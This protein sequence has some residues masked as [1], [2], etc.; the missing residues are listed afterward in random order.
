MLSRLTLVGLG[1]TGEA[2]LL[3]ALLE[4]LGLKICLNLPGKPSDFFSGFSFYGQPPD[5]VILSAHGDEEGIIFPQ[6]AEGVDTLTLPGDRITP[7]LIAER[8]ELPAVPIVSTA[9]SSGT[10]A[11][12]QAFFTA[13]ASAYIAPEG[14]PEGVGIPLFLHMLFHQLCTG[15]PHLETAFAAANNLLPAGDGFTLRQPQA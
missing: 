8:L 13:G 15:S 6:M 3:R 5:A 4:H 11:F 14:D 9:C 7:S 12:V 2:Q 1:D 10:A